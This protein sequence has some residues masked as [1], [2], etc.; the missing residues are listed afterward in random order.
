[1]PH[2][3]RPRVA[4]LALLFAAAL[5]AGPARAEEGWL[6]ID[7]PGANEAVP[8]PLVE[9]R[10]RAAPYG[11]AAHDLVIAIDVSDSVL[12]P[13]GWD[14]DGD[15]P[16][17]RTAPERAGRLAADGALAARMRD[18]DLDDS[19]L[20]SELRAARALL[21]RLDLQRDRVGLVAF[22]DRAELLAPVGSS[23]PQLEAALD[24][25]ESDLGRW[26]R[27]TNF[28]DAVSTAQLALTPEGQGA[29]GRQHS[30]LF[31][32]DGEPTLPPHADM[33]RQHAL[34]AANAAAAAGI[35]IHAFALGL[36][37]ASP[38]AGG[39]VFR[40][41]AERTGGRFERLAQAGDAIAR[42][43]QSDLAGLDSIRIENRTTAGPA[44]ALRTF[45]DGSFDAFVPL[46]PGVNVIRVEAVASDGSRA[47]LDR[48]VV[49]APGG[50][51]SRAA[52]DALLEEL[53]R[54]TQEMRIWAEMER[55]RRTRSLELE[56]RVGEPK[57]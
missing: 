38:S 24:A 41:M 35:R 39:D 53:R 20:A 19:V 56:L 37:E 40:E 26:M 9:V 49:H 44:R 32:S 4:R 55:E 46:A 27:G 28:G 22:S 21:D 31:L 10:G 18:A 12:L 16:G 13:S 33:P 43:R 11:A 1:M 30:V 45:P 8:L 5:A 52:T 14:V 34:W 57:E 17:G 47:A 51:A 6:R 29:G 25:L 2:R 7:A 23:R 48:E 15:G 42:L 36:P 54:R 50:P 3:T